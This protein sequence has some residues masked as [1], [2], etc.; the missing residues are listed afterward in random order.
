MVQNCSWEW[1]ILAWNGREGTLAFTSSVKEKNLSQW[2]GGEFIDVL[3]L[4]LTS[5]FW[6]PTFACRA[7]RKGNIPNPPLPPAPLKKTYWKWTMGWKCAKYWKCAKDSSLIR[8][9]S[10]CTQ[11]HLGPPGIRLAGLLTVELGRELCAPDAASQPYF[12]EI[13]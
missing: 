1:L 7:L 12:S 2:R 8:R 9:K 5:F 3:P 10:I 6:K 13:E 4:I 11:Q